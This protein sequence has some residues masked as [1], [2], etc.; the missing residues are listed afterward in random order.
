M[1]AVP[2]G[3]IDCCTTCTGELIIGSEDDDAPFNLAPYP[4]TMNRLAWCLTDLS[5]LW[6]VPNRRGANVLLPLVPGRAPEPRRDDETDY[7]LDFIVSGVVDENGTLA[8]DENQQLKDNLAYLRQYVLGAVY[9]TIPAHLV[10]PDGIGTPMYA[11]IQFGREP[12]VR[13]KKG[14]GLW[15]GTLHLVIPVGAFQ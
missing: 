12:L 13:K 7:A 8:D 14:S 1:T 2:P 10:P 3:A 6:E 4:L 11:D 15:V 5:P 9:T